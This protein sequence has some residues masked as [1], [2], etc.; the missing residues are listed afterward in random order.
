MI[1]RFSPDYDWGDLAACGRPAPV[2]TVTQLENAF[3]ERTGHAHGVAFRYGRSGLYFLLCALAERYPNP[4]QRRVMMP[5]YTCV[6]VAHAVVLAGFEP[7]FLDNAPGRFQP[8][9]Q[10]YLAA[11][12]ESPEKTAMILPT[13][14][15]GMTEE[16]AALC[17]A[18]RNRYPHVFI[19]Q[20]CAHGYFCEDAEGNVAAGAGD[21]ALFGMNISKLVNSVK[22][23]ML[24][25]RDRALADRIRELRDA[26][27]VRRSSW[28]SRAYVLAATVA[29]TPWGFEIVHWLKQHTRL[30]AGETDYF[31]PDVVDLP[32]DYRQPMTAFEAAI[33]LSSLRRY[34]QRVKGRRTLA[35]GYAEA[36]RPLRNAGLLDFPEPQSGFTWSHFP[37][38]VASVYRDKAQRTLENVLGMEIGII[39]DYSVADLPAYQALGVAGTPVAL[40]TSREVINLPLCL[41][42]GRL[43]LPVDS[44]AK[45]S[46]MIQRMV[47][48]L[49]A[50]LL[51]P[52]P[53]RVSGAGNGLLPAGL[54]EEVAAR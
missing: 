34:D 16:T 17:E 28:I 20:D 45:T 21:G 47:Q 37:V 51:T 33:G 27:P 15:F 11:I 3:A 22:G 23:G 14:L 29:F 32:V 4:E 7:V 2:N 10:A 53:A 36:L 13:H 52:L 30:L 5:S 19:L 46:R 54:H 25:L 39:V 49:S 41:H 44:G 31:R 38:R 6:V 26:S 9:P 50:E 18:I 24:T 42:E 8:L 40:A 1:P 43:G 48:I 35:G 12:E